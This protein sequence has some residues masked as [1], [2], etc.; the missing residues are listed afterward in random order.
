METN[1]QKT[2]AERFDAAF[3]A[4]ESVLR[5]QSELLARLADSAPDALLA[6][7]TIDDC[8]AMPLL[9]LRAQEAGCIK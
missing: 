8:V 6:A 4:L 2:E 1:C 3:A 5:R 9:M 7:M